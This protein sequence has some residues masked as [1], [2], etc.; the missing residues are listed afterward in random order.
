MKWTT[1]LL[2]L[3]LTLAACGAAPLTLSDTP[4]PSTFQTPPPAV[5][6]ALPPEATA[7]VVG[8]VTP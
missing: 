2:A 7:Q 5:D 3:A 1:S 6:R 8:T 4:P